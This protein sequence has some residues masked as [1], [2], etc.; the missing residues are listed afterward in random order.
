MK[1]LRKNLTIAFFLKKKAFFANSEISQKF[2]KLEFSRKKMKFW[3][4]PKNIVG[5]PFD[6]L[7]TLQNINMDGSPSMSFETVRRLSDKKV[8]PSLCFKENFRKLNFAN[9]SQMV[10]HIRG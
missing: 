8:I 5:G 2:L 6:V 1:A 3:S 9:K 4:R 10:R 7:K